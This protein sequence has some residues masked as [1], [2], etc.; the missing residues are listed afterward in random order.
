MP[1][2]SSPDRPDCTQASPRASS[3]PPWPA[4]SSPAS[5]RYGTERRHRAHAQPWPL[6]PGRSSEIGQFR[7]N[8]SGSNPSPPIWIQTPLSLPPPP[9][10][11]LWAQLVGPPWPADALAPCRRGNSPAGWQNAPA[12]NPKMTRGLSVLLVC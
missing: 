9:R 12:L 8:P 6:D 11:C 4:F 1:C 3:S 2:S 5:S 10:L 7:H